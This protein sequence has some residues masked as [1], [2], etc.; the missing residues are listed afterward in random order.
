[1]PVDLTGLSSDEE[2]P[3][4]GGAAAAVHA[5]GDVAATVDSAEANAMLDDLLAFLAAKGGRVSSSLLTR[6]FPQYLLGA[7]AYCFRE[8]LREVAQFDEERKVWSVAG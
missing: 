7:K 6:K 1:M 3:A 2:A 4:P 5:V 8:L